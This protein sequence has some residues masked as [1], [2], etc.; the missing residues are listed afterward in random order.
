[1]DQAQQ[2]KQLNKN[3]NSES[4]ETRKYKNIFLASLPV[5]TVVICDVAV[6]YI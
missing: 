4:K 1:M 3:S 6:Y 5:L 2:E